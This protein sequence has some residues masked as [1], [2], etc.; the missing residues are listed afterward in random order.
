[1][2]ERASERASERFRWIPGGFLRGIVAEKDLTDAS[3]TDWL[4]FREALKGALGDQILHLGF[5]A[6]DT[7]A[8]PSIMFLSGR[9]ARLSQALSL[10]LDALSAALSAFTE[11]GK[12]IWASASCQAA[13]ELA[14]GAWKPW[15]VP[16]WRPA[17]TG[18]GH[19]SKPIVPFWDRC[20]TH[21][22]LFW[23]MFTGGT[24]F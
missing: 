16:S 7:E 20:T 4:R 18:L 10:M 1:M 6:F 11:C 22:G 23:G 17:G 12:G 21:F 5:G 8:C 19:G 9:R 14:S 13:P 3:R 2:R 15:Q 24:G